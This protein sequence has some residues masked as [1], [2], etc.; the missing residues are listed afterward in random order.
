M[1]HAMR[2][3]Y[4]LLGIAAC[5][6]EKRL[7]QRLRCPFRGKKVMV[8]VFTERCPLPINDTGCITLA[9]KRMLFTIPAAMPLD[10]QQCLLI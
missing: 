3:S 6:D 8:M 5:I 9:N 7:R 1:L 10:Q 2:L 4:S